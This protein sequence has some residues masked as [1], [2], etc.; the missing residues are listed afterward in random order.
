MREGWICPRCGKANAPWRACCD[1]HTTVTH[2][3]SGYIE[4]LGDNVNFPHKTTAASTKI[5]KGETYTVRYPFGEWRKN[6]K[7]E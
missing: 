5:H 2:S 7:S 1:C 4:T 3:T 6:D